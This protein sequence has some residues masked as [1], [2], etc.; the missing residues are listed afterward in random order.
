MK[1]KIK[2]FDQ[3]AEVVKSKYDPVGFITVKWG[4]W[5]L[6]NARIPAYYKVVKISDI[7]YSV[8]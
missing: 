5:N 8:I 3:V 4:E 6:L 7:E 1:V 2:G